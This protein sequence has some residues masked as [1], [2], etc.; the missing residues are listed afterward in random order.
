MK[1]TNCAN[2]VLPEFISHPSQCRRMENGTARIQ[3]EN[4]FVAAKFMFADSL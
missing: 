1:S 3:I 2:T 4:T